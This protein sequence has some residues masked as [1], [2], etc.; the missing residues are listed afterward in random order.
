MTSTDDDSDAR[1]QR[2]D[3]M[4]NEFLAAQKRRREKASGAASRP[5][6]TD[7]GPSLAGPPTDDVTGIA[8]LRPLTPCRT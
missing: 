3:W 7:D 1:A 8:A 4:R 2:L 6:D 5:D